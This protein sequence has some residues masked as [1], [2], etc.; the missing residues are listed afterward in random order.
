VAVRAAP[1][2]KPTHMFLLFEANTRYRQI[3]MDGRK[4]PEDPSPTW[5]GHSIGWWEGDA[6]VIDTIG[7]NDKFW[8]DR[9]GHPHRRSTSNGG[10]G[11]TSTL[12]RAVTII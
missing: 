2:I 11:R 4:H 3:F 5:Y 12:R 7:F 1:T 6:L 9:K 10:R 8:F